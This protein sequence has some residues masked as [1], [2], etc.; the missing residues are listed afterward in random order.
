MALAHNMHR[1]HGDEGGF[2]GIVFVD[3]IDKL[4]RLHGNYMDAEDGQNLASLRTHIYP[5]HPAT[6]LP[7]R[8]CCGDPLGCDLFLDG[9]CWTFA[10][11]DRRQWTASG[12]YVPGN[13]L[14]VA[15][16]PVFSGSGARIEEEI[17]RSDIVFS[18]ASLEVGYD[19]P[20]MAFVYQHY[21]PSNLASFIQR[22]GRGGRGN[23]DRP[24]TGVTL[25][26]Y[27]SRDSWYYHR[28]NALLDSR[29]FDVPLNLGN[30]IVLRGQLS[31]LVLDLIARR[32]AQSMSNIRA[33]GAF[34]DELVDEF[35]TVCSRLFDANPFARLGYINAKAFLADLLRRF[36]RFGSEWPSQ[37]RERVGW[38]PKTLFGTANLPSIDFTVPV[39]KGEPNRRAENITL[40]LAAAAPGNATRRWGKTEVHWRAPR[41]GRAPFLTA[42]EEADAKTLDLGAGGE[43][44][45]DLPIDAVEDLGGA[46]VSDTVLRPTSL[47]LDLIGTVR[48]GTWTSLVEWDPKSHTARAISDTANSSTEIDSR[49]TGSLRG[50]PIV[51]VSQSPNVIE[52]GALSRIATSIGAHVGSSTHETGL[53]LARLYWG[54]DA[55]VRVIR[56]TDPI[57]VSQ[58]FTDANGEHA[59]LVGYAMESEGMRFTLDS[60]AIDAFIEGELARLS[61]LPAEKRWHRNQMLRYISQRRARNAG[62]NAYEARRAAELIVTAIDTPKLAGELAKLVKMWSDT[63][64][65]ALFKLTYREALLSH[66]LLSERRIDRLIKTL[67]GTNFKVLLLRVIDVSD[68]AETLRLFLRSQ[69]LH[70]LAVRLRQSFVLHGAGDERSVVAHIKL[71]I[72]FGKRASDV[73]TIVENGSGGDGTTRTFV[74]HSAAAF[75]A[76]MNG[77]ADMCPNA[78]ED[79]L[80][81]LADAASDQHQ[82][83][84][85][86]D[87]RRPE[88]LRAIGTVLGIDFET[89][90]APSP[91]QLLRVLYATET[92]V[93]QQFALY[94]IWREV[95]ASRAALAALMG[96]EPDAWEIVS[97]ASRGALNGSYPTLAAMLAAYGRIEG[98]AQDGSLSPEQRLADQIYR[99]C[100]R[101]CFDGCLACL[102]GD[103]DLMPDGLA[104]VAVSRRLLS[105]FIASSR[106]PG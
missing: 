58:T 14:T 18:T 106:F 25:S 77:F 7:R 6:G 64:L 61:D 78:A 47:S 76:F 19:D 92:I 45:N 74:E 52:P 42:A 32:E 49:S 39:L 55:E 67:S 44:L 98:A 30:P 51:R 8:E 10:A 3:S 85:S 33:D 101:L 35:E 71:P 70:G 105:R 23:D 83:W 20:D 82:T 68:S 24:V 48:G 54:A 91:Q 94:N 16:I 73:I 63:A 29:G 4:K 89:P 62:I 1:R 50:F 46:S 22:K 5:D 95:M 53:L 40:G 90:D 57:G 41:Q 102:H 11:T 2:R 88:T 80:L 65:A 103:S 69:L 17:E 66:P 9:E 15:A 31:T 34:V 36:G 100:G 97:A 21:A 81:D 28:P 79:A 75:G 99:L 60:D 96:R 43:L 84:R 59:Q 86:L 26:I 38:V 93:G 87:P 12:P 37:R 56:Q 104:E 27:S 72:Q 13:P